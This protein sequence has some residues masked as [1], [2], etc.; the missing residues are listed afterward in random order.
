MLEPAYK[1][2]IGDRVVDTTDEPQAS[3][4]VDLTVTLD[5]EAPAD[6]FTVVLGQVGGLAPERGDEATIE[7]GFVDQGLTRVITATVVTAEPGLTS[8]RVIGHSAAES[9]LH[10][11]V[12]QTYEAMM[13]GEV[14]RDLA[15]QAGVDVNNADDGIAFPAYV[16]D[17]RRSFYHHMRDLADLC[18]FD[19]Y[20]TAD[21]KLVFERFTAGKTI[22]EF[23]Y[24]EHILELSALHTPPV[25]AQISAWGESPMGSEGDEAWPWLTKDF[26][27]AAGTA[28]A[29][30]PALLVE[31]PVL[32]TA[33]AAQAAADAAHTCIRRHTLRGRLLAQGQPQVKL[34][35]AVHIRDAPQAALNDTFQVREVVHRITKLAGFTTM[36]GFRA[37]DV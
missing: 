25:A 5:M 31:R 4:L 26:A 21:G 20:L 30:S 8:R 13:A 24:A 15:D 36:I 27:G 37:V 29:G 23:K 22:H 16:V 3:T 32:R 11:F 7:L 33:E 1:L 19:L 17:G 6:S 12:D 28:G 14:V 9:L 34:G 2:V 10:N 18:G 35:D